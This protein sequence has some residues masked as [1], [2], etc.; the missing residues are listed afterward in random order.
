VVLNC[1]PD[2][3]PIKIGTAEY[4]RG[5]LCHAVSQ[6][7]VRLPGPGRTFTAI[8]GIHADAG[9]GSVIFSVKVGGK[10]A[11]RSEVLHCG[12][13]GVPVSVDLG[14]AQE[15]T[16]EV[17][18]AGDG[19]TCAQSDWAEAKATLVDGRE[20]WLGDLPLLT[21]E[22][23]PREAWIPPFSFVYG[24]K[25]S[26]ELLGAWKFEEAVRE[27]DQSRTQRTQSYTDPDTGLAVQC[28]IVE[29]HDYPTVEWTLYFRNTRTADT[30]ILED[31]QALDSRFQ[32]GES[33]EFLLHHN[34]G[35]PCTP[36][37]YGPLETPLGPGASKRISAAGGRPTNTDLSYFNLEWG[38]EGVII[39][40]GWPGQW[41]AH[42]ARDEGNGLRVCAGQELTHFTLHPGEKVRTPLIVLQSWQGN[43]VRAQNV[44]RR[45][46]IDHNLPRPGG[47][48]LDPVF[49]AAGADLFPGL[50]CGQ[51]DEIPLLE[52]YPRRGLKVDYWWR[53]AGWYLC[54]GDWT[55]TGTWEPDPVWYPGSLRAVADCAHANGMK[56]TVWFEP[57]RVAPGTWLYENHPEWLLGGD[58]GSKLLNLGNPEAWNWLVNHIDRLI[59][60]QHIDRYRQDFNIDPLPYW[61]GHD[62]EDRQGITEVQYVEGLLAYWDE[63]KKR[64]PAMPFDCCASGG[65]RNDLEMM[66]RGVP[67][68]KSDYYG[69]TTSSQCQFYGIAS[70]L[71]YFGAGIGASD[72]LYVMRSNMA[73]WSAVCWDIRHDHLNYEQ[74]RRFL[75]EW[76]QVAAYFQGDYYPLT[77]YSLEETVW[78]AWQFDRPDPSASLRAGLGDGIVQAFRRADCPEE[79][80]R[81]KLSGL[82]AEANYT[83]TNLDLPGATEMTGQQ[84]MEQGLPV[85]IEDPPGAAIMTYKKSGSSQ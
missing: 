7:L 56:F 27:L 16:L 18:D 65:R 11:F 57:E 75:A 5:L 85:L 31:L 71:P 24:G 36:N 81:L 54:Q 39:V 74:I 30:P 64:H 42:F 73:P 58:G 14:G 26:D 23:R 44:W 67:L 3:V 43:R 38:Q 10:E 49:S 79:S 72:D 63:L 76:R 53:D 80:I 29:Y 55:Q 60:D 82:E 48:L 37:D 9:G 12:Q 52:G 40:V 8:V 17:S 35:S 83:I 61:R 68:S 50:I 33:G 41:A 15:F 22:P 70:W 34:V 46:M 19:I 47:K 62:A 13:A 28:V 59:T 20:V 2:G 4:T 21:P 51:D 25:S 45:W 78:M 84:L 66:R 6:V 32:R 1:R 77:P 69:G